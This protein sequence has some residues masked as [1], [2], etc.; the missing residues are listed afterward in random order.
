MSNIHLLD[1]NLIDK[2][3]AGEVVERPASV[4]KELVENS[5]DAGATSITVEIKEGGI[6]F[7]RI[8]DNGCG[9]NEGEIPT[10]FLRHATSKIYAI[11]DLEGVLTLGFRGEALSSIAGVSQVEMITKTKDAFTG[12]KFVIHGGK[13]ISNEQIGA[14]TGTQITME[15]LFFNTPAR[16]KFLKKPSIEA[17]YVADTVTRIALGNPH[18]AIKYIN[19]GNTVIATNGSGDLKSCILY[20]YGKEIASKMIEVDYEKS[21]Y[22][23]KGL[24]ALP[25]I[26]R[27]NRNYENF[28]INGRYIRSDIVKNA[29]EDSYKGK[30]MIGK[31]PIFVLNMTVPKGSVDVNVHPTKLEVRFDNEDFIYDFMYE[32]CNRVLSSIN[33]IPEVSWDKPEPVKSKAAPFINEKKEDIEGIIKNR[34]GGISLKFK[35]NNYDNIIS[36]SVN[37]NYNKNLEKPYNNNIEKPV[38]Q[39]YK[40]T[41][42]EQKSLFPKIDE[43]KPKEPFFNNYKIVGQI[44]N[45]YWIIEQN[46]NMYLIDQHA[47]HERALYE[48]FTENFKAEMPMSQLLVTPVAIRLSESEKEV[49][50]ENRE[51]LEGFGFKIEELGV[52]SYA[53]KAVPYI[54]DEPGNAGFFIEIIDKLADKNI[55]NIY[56]TKYDAIAT[57]SCKAAVKG[58]DKLS[59]SEAS[60]LIKKILK[61][62]NPFTC[63]HGRPTIIEMKRY[64]LEK[65]FKRVQS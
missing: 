59:F 26:S 36:K 35:E 31:F 24:I 43:R 33:L 9:I 27:G 25:E 54:F 15:N 61:L 34:T 51:L 42:T 39:N 10:A 40:K 37:T 21:G 48:E 28:F 14:N 56:D 2:I 11:E 58:N 50:K 29:V 7:I 57:I 62:E 18:I 20:V 13:V 23:V 3:A 65:K 6:S 45:T 53:I 12:T 1:S 4:V 52:D 5:I 49:L 8:S 63:P 46:D 47:A 64:E 32:A 41:E 44:F 55:T 16:R 22:K 17:G 19:N 30:L 60:E 38:K